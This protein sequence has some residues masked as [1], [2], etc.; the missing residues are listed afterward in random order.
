MAIVKRDLGHGWSATFLDLP[1]TR[2]LLIE[3]PYGIRIVL[4]GDE[5]KRLRELMDDPLSY[6]EEPIARTQP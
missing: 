2:K 5:V 6:A 4:D 3:G 1:E